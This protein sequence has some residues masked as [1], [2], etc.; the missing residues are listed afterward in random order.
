MTGPSDSIIGD[1]TSS[2]LQRFLT[3]M[4]HHLSVGKGRPVLNAIIV[5]IDENSGKAT[6]IRRIQEMEER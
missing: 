2:V 4:P 3:M 6:S 1:D 5:D